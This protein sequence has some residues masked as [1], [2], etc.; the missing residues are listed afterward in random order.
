MDPPPL[1]GADQV[2]LDRQVETKSAW[3]RSIW[4]RNSIAS[5]SSTQALSPCTRVQGGQHSIASITNDPRCIELVGELS[6]T[7]SRF[8][9][10]WAR[11]DVR[12]RE[13]A[14][15]E[16]DHPLVG[17]LRLNRE[18]LSIDGGSGA[19]RLALLASYAITPSEP[20]ENRQR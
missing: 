3:I 11:H 5:G 14:P 2:I 4:V 18:K 8:R 17:R 15:I 1:G 20:R 7:S 10:L 13:G 12:D 16:L 9:Q 19:E 6:L